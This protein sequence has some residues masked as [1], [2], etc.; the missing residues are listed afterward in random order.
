MTAET[1]HQVVRTTLGTLHV[2]DAG[3]IDGPVA[4]LWPSLFSDGRSSWGAQLPGL[5]VL[6]WRTLLVD[7]PGAGSSPSALRP[8]TM[9]DCAQAAL[10]VLDATSVDRAAI[11][12]LSWGGFVAL[13]VALASP[14]RV[15][16][17]V[18]S[19]TSARRTSG[20]I[21][22]RDLV[23]SHLLR[24]GLLRRPG[25]LVA[26][27][28]LSEHSRRA[29]PQLVADVADTV[30]GLKRHGLATAMRSVLVDR[31]NVVDDLAQITVPALVIAGAE[32][33]A[34][35]DPHSTELAD[36]IPGARLEILPRVAHLAPR[37]APESVSALLADFLPTLVG[38]S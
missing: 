16:G 32:D 30:N 24:A 37:E 20:A 4:L 3:P 33:T 38:R 18:L 13:R 17:L 2:Q 12:G 6:G 21:R 14:H 7:P 9:E 26:S 25:K 15:I 5:H 11:V 34:L 31:S 36:G 23:S 22:T 10:D 28:M 19:N 8:F 27:G 1:H 35:P 29:N